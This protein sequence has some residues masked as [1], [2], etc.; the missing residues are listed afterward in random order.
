MTGNAAGDGGSAVFN[1]GDGGSGGGIWN[2]GDL[3]VVDSTLAEN[4][5]GAGGNSSSL[6]Y[7]RGGSGG[8]LYN[9]GEAVLANS[10]ISGNVARRGGQPSPEPGA[11]G[12]GVVGPTP[13]TCRPDNVTL[14]DNVSVGD[15]AGGMALS[16]DRRRC[17]I[18]LLDVTRLKGRRLVRWRPIAR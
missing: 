3:T 5:T 2:L 9:G 15:G 7:G 4:S 13:E 11:D 8:G 10:T 6:L 17:G 14:L 12:A 1:A 18:V 16:W